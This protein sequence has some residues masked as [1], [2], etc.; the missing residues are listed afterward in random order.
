MDRSLNYSLQKLADQ[1][2]QIIRGLH[3]RNEEIEASI[4]DYKI[5]SEKQLRAI[6]Q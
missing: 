1:F 6:E 4:E 3:E 2:E 5:A